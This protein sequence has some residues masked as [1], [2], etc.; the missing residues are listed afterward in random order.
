MA[1]AE[2]RSSGDQKKLIWAIGL[3][4]VALVTL[5]WTFV[6]FS[7]KPPSRS[8]TI[9]PSASPSPAQ[10]RNQQQ[11]Q[12]NT[13]EINPLDYVA[14]DIRTSLPSVPEPRRNIFA[15][16]EAPIPP[17]P[18]PPQP[19]PPPPAPWLLASISP[20]NV[21][22]KTGD[23]SLE[24]RGDKFTPA[25][26]IV[27]DG[28]T[29]STRYISPQQVSAMVPA[30]MIANPGQRQIV[31]SS[32]D[33]KLYSN[34][35]SLS[36]AAPPTPNYTFVGII[37]KP[38]HIGD[39]AL[40]QDKASKE[41]LSIQRGDILAGR[42]RVTSISDRELV[43]VDTNLKIKHTLQ[44]TNDSDKGPYPPGRPTPKVQSEDDEP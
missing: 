27:I 28:R 41:I 18:T 13:P 2:I 29:F 40:L 24:A 31:V 12:R 7:S 9:G 44:L 42:F 10:P 3:G 37:G 5:W 17:I 34:Q 26:L 11:T 16:Y 23:F 30:A 25:A 32:S 38:R 33:G 6:G 15:F 19:T 20:S 4:V 14:V 43:V 39:T 21:Y 35:L 22:A 36:V 1:A 8:N